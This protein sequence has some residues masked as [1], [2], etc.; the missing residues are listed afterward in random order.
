MLCVFHSLAAHLVNDGDGSKS[1][2]VC[3]KN[4]F[5]KS[6]KL[7]GKSD[8]DDWEAEEEVPSTLV[9]TSRT[10]FSHKRA[11]RLFGVGLKKKDRAFNGVQ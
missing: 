1:E 8:D 10:F 5:A 11:N 9:S 6:Q 4:E 3:S 2:D 7:L